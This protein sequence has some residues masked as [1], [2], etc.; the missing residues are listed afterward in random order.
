[1]NKHTPTPWAVNPIKAQ[2]DAFDHDGPLPVCQM[3]WPTT[4]RS[5]QEALA[6]AARIVHCVNHHDELVAALEQIAE[7]CVSRRPGHVDADKNLTKAEIEA[8]ARAIL[9]KVKGE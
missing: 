1:M 9:A 5:E 4:L 2:V 6:N 7:G 3:L 8:I